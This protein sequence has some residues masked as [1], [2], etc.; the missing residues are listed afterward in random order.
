MPSSGIVIQL[1]NG[2]ERPARGPRGSWPPRLRASQVVSP[3]EGAPARIGVIQ[4]SA[5]T[6]DGVEHSLF[7]WFGRA[8]PTRRQLARA[9]GELRT[10]R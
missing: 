8:H 1:T 6:Q 4:L 10:A 9:S 5:R 2:R 7:V 3:F